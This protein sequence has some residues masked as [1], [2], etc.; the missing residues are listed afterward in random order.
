MRGN[1]CAAILHLMA[2]SDMVASTKDDY[3]DLAARLGRSSDERRAVSE[4][5]SNNRR[6][7][8]HDLSAVRALEAFL[9]RAWATLSHNT[10]SHEADARRVD[11]PGPAMCQSHDA[12]G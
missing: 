4:R 5:V 9:E 8:F 6:R 10:G 11:G 12:R 7:A 1:H 3:V 2:M